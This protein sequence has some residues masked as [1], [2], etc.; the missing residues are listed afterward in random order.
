MMI[1]SVGFMVAVGYQPWPTKHPP[2]VVLVGAVDAD[3]TIMNQIAGHFATGSKLTVVEFIATMDTSIQFQ[4]LIMQYNLHRYGCLVFLALLVDMVPTQQNPHHLAAPRPQGSGTSGLAF[5]T[6]AARFRGGWRWM[7]GGV[8]HRCS[9]RN[10][11]L[12]IDSHLACNGVDG[13]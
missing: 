13:S 4:S 6:H 11:W 9:T 5:A 7:L 12:T 3:V 8:D 2:G 10:H 1:N